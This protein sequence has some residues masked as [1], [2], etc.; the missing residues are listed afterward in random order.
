M[1]KNLLTVQEIRVLGQEYPLEETMATNSSILA[2]R[3]PWTKDPGQLQ[4]MG[5]QSWTRLS[6]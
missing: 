4:F 1:V 2:W 6:D 3:I 5:L